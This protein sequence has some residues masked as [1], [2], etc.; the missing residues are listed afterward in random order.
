MKMKFS[1]L[2]RLRTKEDY[3]F[4]IVLAGLAGGILFP[5][6]L[7]APMFTTILLTGKIP[8][9][10]DPHWIFVP[11]AFLAFFAPILIAHF[12]FKHVAARKKYLLSDFM[13]DF[14]KIKMP[15]ELDD[16]EMMASRFMVFRTTDDNEPYDGNVNIHDIIERTIGADRIRIFDLVGDVLESSIT[17]PTGL[18]HRLQCSQKVLWIYSRHLQLP[19]FS[20]RSRR[21]VDWKQRKDS[22][23]IPNK[24]FSKYYILYG[25]DKNKT[26]QMCTDDM[27][28]EILRARTSDD[29]IFSHA[30]GWV[31]PE[32][33]IDGDGNSMFMF[34][35]NKHS[36]EPEE[37]KPFVQL[38]LRLFQIL[39]RKLK[40]G[41]T[42]DRKRPSPSTESR[43]AESGV[44]Q[45]KLK[46]GSDQGS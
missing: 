46:T 44:G 24:D 17:S 25:S 43:K 2:W 10:K 14:S 42:N 1:N 15:P 4:C 40:G 6:V 18:P 45:V 38:G 8:K 22:I 29:F 35:Q 11:L 30:G 27:I 12:K 7:M 37:L 23:E 32:L 3:S 20:I 19:N 26:K 16:L 5:F 9:E 33:C 13:S 28:A 36:F 31:Y 21:S 39:E 41:R 34:W